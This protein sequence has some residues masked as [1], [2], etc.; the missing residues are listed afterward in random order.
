MAVYLLHSTIPL[1]LP[2]GREV[3]HYLGWTGEGNFPRRLHAHETNH[4]SAKIVQA[5]LA[6]GGKLCLGNYY[7]GLTRDDERQMKRN[8]HIG[9]KCLI[10]QRNQL[11]RR[12]REV[13]T[14][15]MASPAPSGEQS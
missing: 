12:L 4:K 7:P 5:F 1:V 10:C 2:D 6:T 3:R 15:A 13:H 8:G 11:E 14:L 9:S